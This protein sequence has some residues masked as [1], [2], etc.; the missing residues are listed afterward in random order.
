MFQIAAA[1]GAGVNFHAGEDKIY[2]PISHGRGGGLTARPL[3][4]GMLM[5]AQA[6]GEG[7]SRH[8]SRSF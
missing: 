2:T 7:E 4:Y 1:G 6:P 3:Y 5:F 8:L